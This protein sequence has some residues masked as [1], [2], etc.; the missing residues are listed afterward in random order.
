MRKERSYQ[1]LWIDNEQMF[2]GKKEK[3]RT[4]RDI[5]G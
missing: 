5:K 3:E 4:V 2:S 1:K